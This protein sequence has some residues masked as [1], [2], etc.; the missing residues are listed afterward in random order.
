MKIYV[1][2]IESICSFEANVKFFL[3]KC[4]PVFSVD[5]CERG[6]DTEPSSEENQDIPE[7]DS[8]STLSAVDFDASLQFPEKT[9]PERGSN[10]FYCY[11]V[12]LTEGCGLQ[13]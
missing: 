12:R 7:T 13:E 8:Y 11:D 10:N 6:G 1:F 9:K 2:S 3:L 4:E 5:N